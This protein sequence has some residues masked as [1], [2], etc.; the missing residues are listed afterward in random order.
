LPG[1]V[2]VLVCSAAKLEV[3]ADTLII[4]GTVGATPSGVDFQPAGVGTGSFTIGAGQTGAFA[5]L[6]GTTGTIKDLNF[7]SQPLNQSFLL[8]NFV[9]F[10]SNPNLRVDLSFIFLGPS[11]QASCAAPAAHG[12]QCTPTSPLL[13]SPSNPASLTPYAFTNTTATQ[14]TLTFVVSGTA[15]NA[16]NGLSSPVNGV[17]TAQFNTSYQ[18]QLGL[19]STGAPIVTTYSG[20]FTTTGPLTSSVPEP[21]TMLL[22]GTGLAGISARVRKRKSV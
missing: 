15:F 16:A 18:T 20:V 11:P 9:I 4:S 6:A 12:Q 2:L 5:G 7:V 10:S 14:S 1:L 3:R 22:L 21:T 8:S 13:I 19:W 17:F